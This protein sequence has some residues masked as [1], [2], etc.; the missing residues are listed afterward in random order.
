VVGYAMPL[1]A[2][3]VANQSAVFVIT[4]HVGLHALHG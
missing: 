2:K 1:G 4:G 3:R